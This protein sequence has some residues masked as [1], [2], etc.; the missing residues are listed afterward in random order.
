MADDLRATQGLKAE[1]LYSQLIND[2]FSQWL[3]RLA[4]DQ[5]AASEF[6]S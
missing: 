6:K 4:R 2:W 3:E 1:Q 5:H